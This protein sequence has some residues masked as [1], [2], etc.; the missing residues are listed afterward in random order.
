MEENHIQDPPRWTVNYSE[1]HITFCY[2]KLKYEY[3]QK[4]C[5]TQH[6]V[7]HWT[8]FPP[9]DW[10]CICTKGVS[11]QYESRYWT[12]TW[13]SWTSAPMG[14]LEASVR[15]FPELNWW[16]GVSAHETL[17]DSED[18][19]IRSWVIWCL[20]PQKQEMQWPRIVREIS[21][22]KLKCNHV[23]RVSQCL[24]WLPLHLL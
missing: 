8:S 2:W 18:G 6:Q 23:P 12:G 21:W 15:T 14:H 5:H 17:M 16:T 9:S 24:Y 13:T 19:I 11:F 22:R 1:I 3:A 4:K 10:D 20:S 7:I